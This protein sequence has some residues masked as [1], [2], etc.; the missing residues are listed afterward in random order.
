MKIGVISDTHIPSK[1][2]KLSKILLDELPGF[3]LIIHAGDLVEEDVLEELE[4]FAPVKAVAGNVDSDRLKE[5][6][7]LS[8][9]FTLEGYRFAVVHG[10]TFKGRIMEKVGYHF[11]GAD[12]IIFGHTHCPVNKW[13]KGQLY[14]NPGSPT[15]RRFQPNHSFGIIELAE[16]V[17]SK[18]I[19]F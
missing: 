6:L 19:E 2:K 15:D 17:R 12:I 11:S 16:E 3:D 7:P 8:L 1:V 13:I 14:F 9:E 4:T 10:H 5:K 18:I